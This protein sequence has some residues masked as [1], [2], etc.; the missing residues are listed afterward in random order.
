MYTDV[1]AKHF[2]IPRFGLKQTILAADVADLNYG[3]RK[4]NYC[5]SHFDMEAEGVSSSSSNESMSHAS[6]V[7][8]TEE[9]DE[10]GGVV[11]VPRRSRRPEAPNKKVHICP[12]QRLVV[13]CRTAVLGHTVHV[14]HVHIRC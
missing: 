3:I 1:D 5:R 10:E 7:E 9:S 8:F 4:R 14:V 2:R 13:C 11:L 6:D 12:W